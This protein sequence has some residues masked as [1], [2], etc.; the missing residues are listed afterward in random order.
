MTYKHLLKEKVELEEDDFESI[1]DYVN[2]VTEAA[3][4]QG[5]VLPSLVQQA[6]FLYKGSNIDVSIDEF[7]EEK[8][9]SLLDNY[10]ET[11]TEQRELPLYDQDTDKI[12]PFYKT[13]SLFTKREAYRQVLKKMHTDIGFT[14][15]LYDKIP[16]RMND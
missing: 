12:H 2:H 7:L 4:K 15:D 1:E 3:T 11:M 8:I 9:D 13:K 14:E 6:S 16:F 10:N 5:K